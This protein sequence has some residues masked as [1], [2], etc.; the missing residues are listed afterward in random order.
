M[1]AIVCGA[2]E[3]GSS[4][5]RQL[6]NEGN[7]VTIIDQSAEL[8]QR[9]SETLDVKARVGY[10]SHPDVLEDAGAEDADMLIAVTRSDEINMVAC[11]VAH[12]LF[13]IPTKIARVRNQDY[14]DPKWKGLYRKD[15]LPIDYIISPEI[16]VAR[17]VINR[18][19][20]PGAIDMVPFAGGRIRM[21][22]VR[23][24]LDCPL[25]N[26]P[27]L[28]IRE[29]A[30][31]L[32]ISPIG[33]IRNGT[34]T[35]AQPEHVLLPGDDVYF[36]CDA[37]DVKKAMLLF[38]HEEKEARRIIILGGGNI[39]LYLARHM[40]ESDHSAT[41]KVIEVSAKRAEEVAEKLSHCT[42]ING[43]GLDRDILQEANVGAA[44]TLIAVTNDDKVNILSSLLAKRYGAERAVTLVNNMSYGP[45][46]AN[47][48]IDIIV[49]PRETTISSILQHVRRGRILGVHS[50]RDGVAEVIEAQAMETSVLTGKPVGEMNLPSGVILGAILRGNE[51]IIPEETT[52]IEKNDHVVILSLSNMVKKVEKMFAVRLQYF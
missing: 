21:I 45:L 32:R 27:L 5:G 42:V 39:G 44:E 52:V 47:L 12:S 48:G 6:A 1:K 11:Q 31:N 10:A 33:L 29:Q 28:R 50:L 46:V 49:N 36:L 30:P 3:V 14:L 2:G 35:V 18:L 51:V 25:I 7:D 23:C 41:L 16:E 9:V 8:I 43:S 40:D 37:E 26:H 24:L 17:A 38:G 19:H 15:H 20:V 22:A 4:I 34:F 13:S